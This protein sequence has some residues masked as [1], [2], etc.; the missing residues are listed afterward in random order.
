MPEIACAFLV[1]E[2]AIEQRITRAKVKMKAARIP[3]RLPS[4]ADLPVRLEGVLTVL[5]L[6]FN[7]G[8]LAS[9][10]GTE[11]VRRELTAEAIRL[12]RL[13]HTLLLEDGE[14]VGL[15]AL[16]LLTEARRTARISPD[17]E[18]VTLDQ[19]DRTRWDSAL[20]DEGHRL[21]RDRLAAVAGAV[22]GRY[23][24]LA[25]IG[26]VHTS[27][28]SMPEMD[29]SQIVA[30]YDQ[31]SR[32]DSSPIVTLNRAIAVGEVDGPQQALMILDRLRTDLAEYHLFHA[33]R[34]DLFR[35]LGRDH[36]AYS[37]YDMAIQLT[38]NTAGHAALT[39]RR[40][41]LR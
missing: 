34:A 4:A 21:V 20:I 29:W 6:V 13:L 17:G 24:I 8:Y 1:R 39:H 12:A 35:R 11:P 31:L 19:Q 38:R 28:R 22:P 23:Q 16:M 5:Y 36:D 41:Q 32:L 14:V 25:A 27:A 2:T 30:L 37:A 33:A 9:G 10:S 26:A 18:L 7:Q 3:Y 15:L 40:D